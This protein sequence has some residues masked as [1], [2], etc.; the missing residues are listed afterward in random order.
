MRPQKPWGSPGTKQAKKARRSLLWSKLVRTYN[1]LC[2]FPAYR[3][4]VP[5]FARWGSTLNWFHTLWIV[6]F[7]PRAVE[8]YFDYL[9]GL[10]A[11]IRKNKIFVE[12]F[13]LSPL[14]ALF[15]TETLRIDQDHTV[16]WAHSDEFGDLYFPF[17]DSEN[18]A[19]KPYLSNIVEP[20][21]RRTAPKA[22]RYKPHSDDFFG[23]SPDFN[24]RGLLD[25]LWDQSKGRIAVQRESSA[26]SWAAIPPNKNVLFGSALT[27]LAAFCAKH[28][29]YVSKQVSRTYLYLG[30]PGGGKTTFAERFAEHA[31]GRLLRLSSEDL[32]LSRADLAYLLDAFQ[33]S[34][35]LVEDLDHYSGLSR[36]ISKLLTVFTDLKVSHPGIVIVLTVNDIDKL[37]EALLRPGRVD[38]II[39]FDPP[40]PAESREIL[41]G[42][43]KEFEVHRPVDLDRLLD[44]SVGMTGPFLKEVARQCSVIEND[45]EIINLIKQMR[46][47]RRGK[48][49]SREY[50]ASDDDLKEEE[51]EDCGDKCASQVKPMAYKVSSQDPWTP[52]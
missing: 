46:R 47:L 33:P 10:G 51:S 39:E 43:L 44:A 31:G 52:S 49:T 9:A 11:E 35:L 27:R 13:F 32:S 21:N 50:D 20:E 34:V 30:P 23:H 45:D 4:H 7:P 14:N 16:L 36:S 29:L 48:K 15:E 41:D 38:E 22:S 6:W 3:E 18:Q 12:L 25:R 42:Y 8:A 2:E 28:D 37:P 26:V 17:S 24:F 1:I 40:G 19:T 5:A